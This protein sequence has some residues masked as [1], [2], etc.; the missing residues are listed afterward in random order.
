MRGL[1]ILAEFEVIDRIL[2]L[3]ELFERVPEVNQQQIS[4]V[5]DQGEDGRLTGMTISSRIF[6]R[7]E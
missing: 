2:R 3:V 6:E 5:T 7:R 4:L 1:K